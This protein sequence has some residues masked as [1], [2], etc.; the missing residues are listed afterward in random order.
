MIHNGLR[1]VRSCQFFV[2]LNHSPDLQTHTSESVFPFYWEYASLIIGERKKFGQITYSEKKELFA[3]I[4]EMYG[5]SK[6]F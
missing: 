4:K 3:L 5:D 1:I 2:K 6:V